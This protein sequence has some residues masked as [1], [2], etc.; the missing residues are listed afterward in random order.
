LFE[1]RGPGRFGSP[2]APRPRAPV[3]DLTRTAGDLGAWG[4][5]RVPS[6]SARS[7]GSRRGA[8]PLRRGRRG[9]RR[10]SGRVSSSSS[11]ASARSPGGPA[12]GGLR[13]QREAR[14]FARAHSKSKAA[15]CSGRTA[16]SV[17]R[18]RRSF[19]ERRRRRGRRRTARAGRGSPPPRVRARGRPR[20]PRRVLPRAGAKPPPAAPRGP[21]AGRRGRAAVERRQRPVEDRARRSEAASAPPRRGGPRRSRAP[22]RAGM[23]EAPRRTSAA[24]TRAAASG[25]DR[26]PPARRRAAPRSRAGPPRSVPARG[27]DDVGAG[28]RERPGHER[29]E[30]RLARGRKPREQRTHR[31]RGEGRLE[32]EQVPEDREAQG[33]VL[34]LVESRPA[35]GSRA[36][37]SPAP[38]AVPGR[39]RR[40]AGARRMPGRRGPGRGRPPR[41]GRDGRRPPRS[42]AARRPRPR[43]AR[44]R[45]CAGGRRGRRG[46][47]GPRGR[48]AAP[49]ARPREE[50]ADRLDHAG[51]EEGEPGHRRVAVPAPGEASLSS[52]SCMRRERD[53]TIG[54]DASPS[55]L[56]SRGRRPGARPGRG[57]G[58]ASSAVVP[59]T[60]PSG[61]CCR[62]R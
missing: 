13:P 51:A 19:S 47:R 28:A 33:P 42:R 11:C 27:E 35:S 43:R 15:R 22:S 62:P 60:L 45:G 58:G 21:R 7:C 37:T 36:S 29:G 39:P 57:C 16:R 14:A 24:V 55:R 9:T 52:S 1:R 54:I 26:A 20:R 18:V 50:R 17:A 3:Y 30:L 34:P 12:A 44:A 8:E 38:G 56:L 23:A 5:S 4:R 31:G 40:R 2:T 6:S 48:P 53:G 25:V 41:A 49:G 10:C 59:L 46:A 61:K 32:F